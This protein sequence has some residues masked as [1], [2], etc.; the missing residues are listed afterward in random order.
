MKEKV[1]KYLYEA[2]REE[3]ALADR[4]EA[5]QGDAA[6]T[7]EHWSGKDHLT[8]SAEWKRLYAEILDARRRGKAPPKYDEEANEGIFE[9]YRDTAWSGIRHVIR[10]AHDRLLVQLEKLSEEALMEPVPAGQGREVPQWW[11]V[12]GAGYNHPM[13]HIGMIYLLLEDRVGGKAA[14]E[15]AAEVLYSFD[16]SKEWQGSIHYNL[17]CYYAQIGE[18]DR[19]LGELKEGLRLDPA[20]TEWSKKDPDFAALRDDPG[21]L[22]LYGDS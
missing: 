22:G 7:F 14:W 3:M 18:R 2:L 5:E 19:A 11:H 12:L 6:G 1:R 4:L 21:Y 13:S 20:L 15:H 8:H 17:A 16:D 10:E 9:K